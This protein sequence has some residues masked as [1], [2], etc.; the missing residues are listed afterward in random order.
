MKKVIL[1]I[2][3]LAFSSCSAQNQTTLDLKKNDI[4]AFSFIENGIKSIE[5]K[6]EQE[7]YNNNK[8]I[9]LK[10]RWENIGKN[11]FEKEF[12]F[13][14]K[15]DTMKISCNCGQEKNLYF[16]DLKFEKGEIEIELP[17]NLNT[18]KGKNIF[19]DKKLN[20]IKVINSHNS[21]GKG[22]KGIFIDLPFRE[23]D[24]LIINE[25]QSSR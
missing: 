18:E 2:L 17:S 7:I 10:K 15:L 23:L 25:N 8:I 12:V 24:F 1:I 13:V 16:K 22:Q 11:Y 20:N 21:K 4:I 19:S 3:C 14:R 5:S 9:I 6:Y